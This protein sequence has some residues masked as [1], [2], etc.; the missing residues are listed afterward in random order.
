[1]PEIRTER[2]G[3]HVSRGVERLWAA[4]RRKKW[5]QG[6]LARE[7]GCHSGLVNKWMHAIQRPS[8]PFALRLEEVLAIPAASWGEPPTAGF[9]LKTTGTEG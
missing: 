2:L 3:D 9:E 4:L 7:L 1:M 8:L 5:T 6:E